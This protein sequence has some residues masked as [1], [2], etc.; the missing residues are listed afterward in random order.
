MNV[1]PQPDLGS[2]VN[3]RSQKLLERIPHLA[4]LMTDRGSMIAVNRHWAEFTGQCDLS[5]ARRWRDRVGV[6][7]G[8]EAAPSMVVLEKS[9][10]LF[11]DSLLAT[12][13]ERFETAWE[14]ARRW[15]IPLEIKLQFK[16]VAE[17][18]WFRLE[19]EPDSDEFGQTIWICTAIRLGGEAV[20]PA[21]QSTQFLEAL[22]DFASDGIVAC[23]A[24]GRLVLFNRMA[25]QFHGLPPE[26]LPPE[27]WAR[28]YDLYDGDG[29]RPLMKEEIPL[30]GALQGEAVVDREMT[31]KPRQGTTRSLVANA[32]AIYNRETGEKLGAVALMR[33]V[34]A[35][36]HAMTELQQSERK[37]RAIFDGVF[38]FIGLL[39]PDGTLVE[40]NLTALKFG[41]IQSADALG[42]RFWEVPGWNFSTSTQIQLSESTARAAQGEFIR[43]E[44]ELSGAQHQPIPI[45]FSLT[46]IL[47]DRGETILLIVEGR[48]IS[49]IKSAQTE[50]SRAELYSQ[51]LSIGLR[52]AKAAGWTWHLGTQAVVWTPEFATL[53]DCEPDGKQ[54]SYQEW[55]ARIHP[56]DRDRVLAELQ[57]TIDREIPVY[58]CEYR[59]VWRNG[60]IRWIDGVGELQPDAA[61]DLNTISG[62]FYDI[63]DRKQNEESLQR[64]EEFT[65]RILESTQDCIKVINLDGRVVYMNDGGQSLMEIDDFATIAN[66]KWIDFWQAGYEADDAMAALNVAKAGGVGKFEGYCA[67]AKGTP[68]WWEVIV[69]HI[70][71]AQGNV[72]Q[73]LAVSRDITER[74]QAEAALQAS[75]TLF[76]H[77]FEYTCVGF[78][79]VALDGTWLR[80]NQKLC[81][82]VGYSQSELLATTFQAITEPVDL[83][84]DLALAARL[85]KG[86]ISEYSIEKRYIHKQGHPVWVN[87]TVSLL[88]E[89]ESDGSLGA[90]KHYLGA[91]ID[92]T[93]RK[94]LEILNRTQTAELLQL[95]DSLI[96][97]Q[98]QL[99]ERN[100][101]LDAFVYMVSHD[102][103][104]PLRSIANLSEW[105]EEDLH[106]RIEDDDSQQ[107]A[108]LRQRV[109]RMDAL[110]DGLLRYSRVGAQELECQS[111]DIHQLVTE[112][113]DSLAPPTGFK[114]KIVSPLPTAH[115]KRILL[116]QIFANLLSNA[117]KHHD[118]PDG[119]VE[120][121]VVDLGDRYRFAI[122][123]DGPGIPPGVDRQRIFEMFQT[124]KPSVST[125]NT[126]IGLALVK[127][128]VEG[129]GGQIWLDLDRAAGACF[130]FTWLK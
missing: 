61:G 64:S 62:L 4:W 16:G 89:I 6:V 112:T 103:K 63:T 118:R 34:T 93:A 69:T 117:I 36:K 18:E 60:Q 45:D 43:Y 87:L 98:H 80:V 51:R 23:D 92:I 7:T 49:Q 14:N 11:E 84:A 67:T 115:T 32:R 102:L 82:I 19:M 31:I 25:Q 107:F 88:R 70:Q 47:N 99:K 110:I 120:I 65:R 5:D 52:V 35:Y 85:V 27:E 94:E 21:R 101:E 127:K 40:V 114:M 29:M 2:I 71:D 116:A 22:L 26:P 77:T 8:A 3:V 28:Y 59:V 33:D 75:E 55:L 56:D 104:A 81:E 128:I 58:R 12:D 97:A 9:P 108:L 50:R 78:C 66:T 79:H 86:E 74:K 72:V 73:L 53:F 38:Q 123:D 121:E 122:A 109:K 124:L 130:C 95:N 44:V 13:R 100:E 39:E 20:V 48:D 105:I 24:M 10:R 1:N 126:G 119:R 113:I 125:E 96:L 17:W 83:E 76:R 91:I 106:G 30:F 90:P 111:V 42:R 68:K 15:Q 57:K 37:F 129:E 41:G 46:P 54:L